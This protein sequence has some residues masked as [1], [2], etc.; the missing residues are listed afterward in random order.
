MLITFK[1]LGYRIQLN[2]VFVDLHPCLHQPNPCANP[3]LIQRDGFTS[4]S[5]QTQTGNMEYLC[6][7]HAGYSFD[8]QNGVCRGK[9]VAL[10][11][12]LC[13]F[14]CQ[15]LMH[16]GNFLKM[17]TKRKQVLVIV[18]MFASTSFWI[19]TE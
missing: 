13:H 5:C 10:E 8:P 12:F 16:Y 18:K 6:S 17:S 15:I 11:I 4:G 3:E 14:F 19:A 1:R 7:C 9:A 2:C